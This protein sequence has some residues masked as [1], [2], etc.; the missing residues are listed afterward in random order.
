MKRALVLACGNPLRGDD[1]VALHVARALVTGF[2]DEE[3][4][5]YSQHQWLPENAET[6]SQSDLVIFVDASAEFAAGQVRTRRVVAG[7]TPPQPTTHTICPATLLA[8]S[9]D[10]FGKLPEQ[11]FL[12]TV[13]GDSFEVSEHLS[14]SVRHAIP[15]ALA[16]V[17]AVLSGVSVPDPLA[18]SQGASS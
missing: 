5:V 2:C 11:S 14:D 16:H 12:V 13:G 7:K 18:R 3:T 15:L 17:K 4:V 6:I 10:L 9:R 8:M 1:A